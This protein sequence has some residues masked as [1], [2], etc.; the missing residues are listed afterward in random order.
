MIDKKT[1]LQ[2]YRNKTKKQS[3]ASRSNVQ[4]LSYVG[5]LVRGETVKTAS[6]QQVYHIFQETHDDNDNLA[7]F[8]GSNTTVTLTNI[9][10]S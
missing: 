10:F 6:I 7:G 9:M 3:H 2:F 8:T 5:V 1:N 4:S